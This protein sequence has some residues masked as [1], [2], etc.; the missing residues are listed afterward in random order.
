MR[1]IVMI[2]MA[3]DHVRDLLHITSLTD[4][5]TNL[6]T[7]T[8]ELFF[9]RWITHLCASTFVF[10]SGVSAFIS[11]KS[12][13]DLN[14]T[15]RFLL[16][17]GLWLIVLEFTLVNFGLLFDIRFKILIFEV[18]ATIGFG[19]II[20]ALLINRSP[21]T[22]GIIGLAIMFLH[23]LAPLVPGSESSV[24]KKV[25]MPFFA[26]GILPLGGDRS[27]FMAY[28]PIPWL[29]IML[30]GFATARFFTLEVQK[31]R[32]VFLKNCTRRL[33]DVYHFAG[34]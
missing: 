31:Q 34:H 13:N 16:T 23:N 4:Q 1:G 21:K 22:I 2:I 12:R 20:L 6:A 25:L 30:I 18:I 14:A 11:M 10:L 17:R 3:L 28:P 8:P 29:A 5:P 19:F 26:P 9:T 33:Y 15:R 24:F 7:T 32:P 27:F